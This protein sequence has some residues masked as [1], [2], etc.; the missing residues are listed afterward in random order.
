[1]IMIIYYNLPSTR[2]VVTVKSL[3][4]SMIIY[5]F[6]IV[7][8][9]GMTCQRRFFRLQNHILLLLSSKN[10][11]FYRVNSPERGVQIYTPING[12]VDD[13]VYG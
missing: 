11:L 8:R 4:N 2:R 7:T 1:M 10:L 12:N 9:G 5:R 3:P 6:S 13:T